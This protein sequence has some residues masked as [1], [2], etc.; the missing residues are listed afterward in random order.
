MA[1]NRNSVNN[2]YVGSQI[3]KKKLNRKKEMETW[4]KL[5]RKQLKEGNKKK[6]CKV[7]ERQMEL[8][9]L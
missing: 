5:K 1:K 7:N 3:N 4:A 8:K 9:L 2:W 6:K